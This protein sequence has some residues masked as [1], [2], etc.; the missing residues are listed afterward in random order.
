MAY[1]PA[2]S[3]PTAT[4]PSTAPMSFF[5]FLPDFLPASSPLSAAA[6]LLVSDGV[7]SFGAS[8][9]NRYLHF[10]HSTFVPMR[11]GFLMRTFASQLGQGTLNVVM[12][13]PTRIG[14]GGG[15]QSIG[16]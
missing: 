13:R 16:V 11:F 9:L 5:L 7:S 8:T 4:T 2:A 10:G 12:R 15:C 14:V 1:P 3:R 6:G